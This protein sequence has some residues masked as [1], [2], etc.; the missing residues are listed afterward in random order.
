MV[1]KKSR[2]VFKII[3]IAL[4]FAAVVGLGYSVYNYYQSGAAGGIVVCNPQKPDECFWQAHIHTFIV[5]VACEEERRLPI[6]SGELQEIHSHEEKNVLHWHASV[7]YDRQKQKIV[8]KTTLML[9]T[10]FKELNVEFNS[11]CF[12]EKCND[13]L[14][15]DGKPGKLKMFVKRDGRW[16]QNFDFEKFVWLDQDVIYLAFDSRADEEILQFLQT[17]DIR[18]PVL[19]VG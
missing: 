1:R 18:F 7:P 16:Q 4:V 11:T 5:P 19:G 2:N 17:S 14:C 15:A 8:D 6:E 3:I 9:G 10:A 12:F 13:D